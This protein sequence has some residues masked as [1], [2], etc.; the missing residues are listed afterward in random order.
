MRVIQVDLHG[1]SYFKAKQPP[2]RLRALRHNGPPL[3]CSLPVT[4]RAW[5]RA[6]QRLPDDLPHKLRGRRAV[7]DC[8]LGELQ[9]LVL[10]KPRTHPV[11]EP[12]VVVLCHQVY[13]FM[14]LRYS[15]ESVFY[16]DIIVVLMRILRPY[17]TTVFCSFSSE[18]WRC[19]G[20]SVNSSLLLFLLTLRD[21]PPH[22]HT[23]ERGR[24]QP[25]QSDWAFVAE[26]MNHARS[27]PGPQ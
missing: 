13:A 24:S 9:E 27:A 22:L 7:Q 5:R 19:G 14:R 17:S 20:S 12:F 16:V 1:T 8:P 23:R 15:G 4:D 10:R 25:G 26:M 6:N 11:G 21:A 3:C 18:E 2:S